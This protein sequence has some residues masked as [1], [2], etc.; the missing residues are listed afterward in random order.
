MPWNP[1]ELALIALRLFRKREFD[2]CSGA[3][4]ASAA[5]ASRRTLLR[6]VTSRHVTSRLGPMAAHALSAAADAAP[7]WW[8]EFSV[9]EQQALVGQVI[10]RI[11]RAL[12]D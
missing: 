9:G 2:A 5:R 3:D 6:H 1:N 7:F 4:V 8:V 10:D 11:G 12:G